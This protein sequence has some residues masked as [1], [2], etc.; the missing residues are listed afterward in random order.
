MQVTVMSDSLQCNRYYNK[1][2]L[3]NKNYYTCSVSRNNE[4]KHYT[5]KVKM[6]GYVHIWE[7]LRCMDEIKN[8][9]L[10]SIKRKYER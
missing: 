10:I 1:F 7:A 6:E 8:K 3:L 2:F 4:R 5:K 9:F